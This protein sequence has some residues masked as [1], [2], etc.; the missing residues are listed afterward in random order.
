V[1]FRSE[2]DVIVA[3]PP[4]IP[5]G[6][7]ALLAPEVALHD[8]RRALDGGPDGLDCYRV[9]APETARLLRKGGFAAFE[10]G[11]GQTQPVLTLMRQAGLATVEILR[12]LAGI[13][14]CLVVCRD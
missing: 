6:T 11:A 12:D 14:R 13:E 10:F 5:S 7:I 2:F 3:N 8:P 4:Y 9:L 1:L